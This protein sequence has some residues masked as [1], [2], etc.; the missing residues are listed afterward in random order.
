M[1]DDRIHRAVPPDGT[2]VAARVRG[3]GPL[4]LLPAGPATARPAGVRSSRIGVRHETAI[5]E[6]T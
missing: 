1:T 2:D 5:E 3:D 6:D 4:V